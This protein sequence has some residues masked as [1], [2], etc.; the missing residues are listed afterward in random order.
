MS[1]RPK[2][3]DPRAAVAYVR[4]ST[5]EQRLGPEAQRAQ[6]AAWAAREGVAVAAWHVDQ[7][8]SGGSDVA[9]R[10]ALAAALGELRA[11]GCG[12][13]VVAKRDRLARDVGVVTAI[14]RAAELAG[15]RVVAAD[16]AGNGDD[17]AA[18]FMRRLLDAAAEYERELIRARTRAALKV[19]RGRG[20]LAGTVPF[21]FKVGPDGVLLE[22]DPREQAVLERVRALRRAGRTL[23]AIV[24]ALDT[25]GVRG[26]TGRPLAVPQ[27]HRM[28]APR[29]P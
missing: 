26:R 28:L 6:I 2:P 4:V 19:K 3:G 25:E 16:G 22:P 12:V 11:R 15:A 13:L 1:R 7:G 10:P 8:V 23:R 21:G 27:V 20:E 29:E 17:A 24:A 18:Q 14:E 9:D 5:D